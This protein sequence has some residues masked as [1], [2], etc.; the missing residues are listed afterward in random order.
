MY[1]SPL[2]VMQKAGMET[3]LKTSKIKNRSSDIIYAAA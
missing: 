1:S 3:P 2:G